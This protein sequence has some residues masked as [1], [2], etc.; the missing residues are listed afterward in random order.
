[1]TRLKHTLF[2]AFFA[3]GLGPA[4][5]AGEN[6]M[7][8]FDGSNSMWGQI[9]GVAKIE[10]A[11]N[12]MDNLLGDWTAERD[13]GLMAYGHRRRGDCSDI[14]TLVEPGADN[15]RDILARINAITPTGKTPLTDAVEQAAIALSYT[16][17][18]AT[19]V[20]I[21]D[22]L[23]SCERDPCALAEALEQRGVEF[24]AHV[25]G[26]GLGGDE[27]TA[28]LSCI[29]E[30]TGGQFLSASN[31]EELGAA[32]SAVG[33][34][35]ART[36]D[37]EPVVEPEPEPE[38][39]L[40]EVTVTGPETAITGSDFAVSWSP[41]L[42]KD[43]YVSIVPAGS[44]DGT[45]GNYTV[46]RDK[47]EG[48][49]RAPA[50]AGLYEL[51]YVDRSTTATL[52]AAPIEIVEPEITIS[53]PEGVITGA[54]FE[55]SYT[56]A[57][58]KDDYV[59]IVPV[60]ADERS[61]GNYQTVRDKSE[62]TLRAPAEPGLYEVR[63]ILR[64]GNKTMAR[65]S[66]E[67]TL[68]EVT[69][70]GPAS[71]QTGQPFTVSYT[72]AVHEDDYVTIVPLGADEGSYGNYQTVRDR[73]ERDLKAP[74]EPGMYE[75]RY[76]L[77][78]GNKTMAS[79]AIEVTDAQVTLTGPASAVTG[80]EI[81]VRW[82]GAVAQDDYITVVPMGADEGAFGNYILVR[83]KSEGAL[84]MPAETGMYELRYVLRQGSKTLATHPI[85]ITFPEVT[86]SGPATAIAGADIR[87]SWTGTVS[88][89]DYI[90][91]VPAGADEGAFGSYQLVRDK[92]ELNLQ[93]PGD[94]GLYELRYVLREGSRTM[95]SQMIEAKQADVTLE[96]ADQLRLGDKLRVSWSGTV[97][98]RDYINLVP[99]GS[100]EDAFGSYFQV[101]DK[102][103]N[104]MKS[105]DATGLYELRYMLHANNRVLARRTVE[106]L[107]ADAAL[108]A[109]AS[110]S[111]PESAAPGA[112]VEIGWSVDSD[113][114]DQRITIANPD[115]A[116]FTWIRAVKT[117]E[118][119]PVQMQMPD[120]PGTYEL[121]FLDVS[122]Q[123][124]L[125]RQVIT[126]E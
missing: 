119:P 45:Y 13:V 33:T 39:E 2:A 1:M 108:N 125:A 96:A 48:S 66:V 94:P 32:L 4:A 10:I 81:D 70:S 72:G 89:N 22:G 35:V 46:T 113:S 118:G 19:V 58:N 117:S 28:S 91:I 126:I 69:I 44:E 86:V 68:A 90:N 74:A 87:V 75:L 102:T 59:T 3:C 24:T 114:A 106:V 12:V 104:D 53:A 43:D 93:L 56:G 82:S 54:A 76:I 71:V 63:Y 14:Q 40:P 8:V 110:L 61:Y 5:Q 30:K 27:D 60:G 107:A 99:M 65:T 51:R 122:N 16:D 11:R 92:S 121:R 36:P 85:E 109:G 20:L 100:D 112:M 29:A 62:R 9:D 26:F 124:V 80:A 105:P 84:R 55:V 64:E 123:A 7:V 111:A 97:G 95:A 98:A 120:Q 42:G 15:R 88:E 79:A 34:A 6:V 67:V 101:R 57:V 37:P 73:T 115:Q 77:R 50:D 21:S 47:T 83:D 23:E 52:G 103:Q 41:V 116:I 25:V 17:R 18:P 31:A 49:L 78:E 38:P